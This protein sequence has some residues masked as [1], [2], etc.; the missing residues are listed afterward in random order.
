MVH[1]LILMITGLLVGYF[2]GLYPWAL[3]LKKD[4][5][6]MEE[7]SAASCAEI[8]SLKSKLEAK[9]EACFGAHY[10]PPLLPDHQSPSSNGT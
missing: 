3:R 6:L 7:R 2:L 8:A 5:A 1:D 4:L 9:M 10:P